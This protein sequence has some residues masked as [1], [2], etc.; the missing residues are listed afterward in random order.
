MEDERGDAAR[1]A[2][3]S[4]FLF[5]DDHFGKIDAKGPDFVTP[6]KRDPGNILLFLESGWIL[7]VQ[8][9]GYKIFHLSSDIYSIASSGV[10]CSK[11]CKQLLRSQIR[12]HP[13]HGGW[14][15]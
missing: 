6:L 13:S 5:I 10:F 15:E 2:I 3:R 4:V 8:G 1:L 12:R 7:P 14:G 9:E 11:Y